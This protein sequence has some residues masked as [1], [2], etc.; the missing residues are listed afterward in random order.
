[1]SEDEEFAQAFRDAD[2]VTKEVTKLLIQTRE[3]ILRLKTLSLKL[4]ATATPEQQRAMDQTV[5]EM[6]ARFDAI[7][8]DMKKVLSR[9]DQTR[10]LQGLFFRLIAMQGIMT[11]VTQLHHD[12]EKTID[13]VQDRISESGFDDIG[14]QESMDADTNGEEN[15]K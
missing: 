2:K 7:T 3:T 10:E 1:M 9:M 5:K 14:T 12:I 15:D 8:E 11:K 13:D 6:S 4:H